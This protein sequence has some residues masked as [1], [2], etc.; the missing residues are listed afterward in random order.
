MHLGDWGKVGAQKEVNQPLRQKGSAD[1]FRTYLVIVKS[2]L[3]DADSFRSAGSFGVLG[4]VGAGG[5]RWYLVDNHSINDDALCLG[6]GR[7]LGYFLHV[8][9]N[10][11]TLCSPKVTLATCYS[12][13][14]NKP[15]IS[16]LIPS[17]SALPCLFLYLSFCRLPQRALTW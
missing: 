3:I 16:E 8:K 1:V 14:L 5:G 17:F 11:A 2:V 13:F 12:T 9:L 4:G 15:E 10:F 6:H 7:Q